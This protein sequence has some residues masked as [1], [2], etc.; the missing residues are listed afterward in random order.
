M[1][2]LDLHLLTLIFAILGLV[3]VHDGRPSEVQMHVHIFVRLCLLVER[4]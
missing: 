3:A 2:D 4:V 1:I